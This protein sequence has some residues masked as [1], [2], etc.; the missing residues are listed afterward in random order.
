MLPNT[1]TLTYLTRF[2]ALDYG[3]G[4]LDTGRSRTRFTFP[5]YFF[6]VPSLLLHAYTSLCMDY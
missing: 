3:F 2:F 5:D 4:Q 1:L 6:C